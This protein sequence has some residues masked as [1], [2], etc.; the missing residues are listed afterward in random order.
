MP[1]R[2]PTWSVS[3][4]APA[5]AKSS[6]ASSGHAGS[7]TLISAPSMALTVRHTPLSASSAERTARATAST[8]RVSRCPAR[9][10]AAA[11][12]SSCCGKLLLLA[13]LPRASAQDCPHRKD[14]RGAGSQVP[15]LKHT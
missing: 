3:S 1:P 2:A 4:T 9:H 8:C 5:P 15:L 12:V 10:D 7:S 13:Q 14:T 6:L 11:T